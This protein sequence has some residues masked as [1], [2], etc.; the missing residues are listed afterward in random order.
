M[1]GAVRIA[2]EDAVAEA[3][4]DA[5][6]ACEIG[7]VAVL[8]GLC[9]TIAA[10]R[11]VAVARVPGAVV[12]AGERP[13]GSADQAAVLS[14]E[15]RAVARFPHVDVPVAAAPAAAR[16]EVAVGRAGELA[17]VE[18]G[19][20]ARRFAHVSAVAELAGPDLPITR[21]VRPRWRGASFRRIREE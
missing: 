11:I 6:P 8:A 21:S 19:P 13:G 10:D 1:E 15:A 17:G 5:A 2:D 3:Q 14:R 20:E 4:P 9:Q 18:A 16:V 12:G 7:A